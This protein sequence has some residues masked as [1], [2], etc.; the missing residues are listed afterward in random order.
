VLIDSHW[1]R[2][3]ALIGRPELADDPRYH[4]TSGRL[5]R[6]ADVDRLLADW[7]ASR[8]V[9]EIVA[10]FAE[11][12]IPAAAVRSYHEAAQDPGVRE[13]D[14]LQPTRWHDGSSI[15]VTGPAAKL[16]RTPT[17]VRTPAPLLGAD[18]EAVL[19][20][21]GYSPEAIGHLAAA[22]VVQLPR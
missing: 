11:I 14:M 5:E 15:P 2:L 12:G 4:E 21:A 17:R 18:G 3:A 16:S 10:S 8:T 1:K 6:R 7:A 19:A 9:A 20:E 22:G 13:R